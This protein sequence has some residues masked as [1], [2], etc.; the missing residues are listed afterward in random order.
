MKLIYTLPLLLGVVAASCSSCSSSK[1]Q[2]G[3]DVEV[4]QSIITSIPPAMT[5]SAPADSAAAPA[6]VPPPGAMGVP[7]AVPPGAP[8]A[9]VPPPGASGVPAPVSPDAA[10]TALVPIT[11][12]PISS[13]PSMLPKAILY[14]TSGDYLNNVP[15]Q[16]AADGSLIGFPAPTDIPADARP[17]VLAKGWILSPIGV[18]TNSVFTKWTLDEYRALKECPT[19]AEIL[20]AII[21]GAKVT[22][23]IQAPM[24]LPEALAD[25]AAVNR[26]LTPQPRQ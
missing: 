13:A 15:V 11:S 10:V 3:T 24:T 19:P 12:M 23:T 25:T 2:A 17:V 18:S 1:K 22:I 14:K 5:P 21:P 9:A 16:I 7:G 20:K 6:A 8:P 26:F 4:D